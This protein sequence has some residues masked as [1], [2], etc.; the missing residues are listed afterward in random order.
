MVSYGDLT[1]WIHHEKLRSNPWN[2]MKSSLGHSGTD[3]VKLYTLL[4]LLPSKQNIETRIVSVAIGLAL[5]IAL[6]LNWNQWVTGSFAGRIPIILAWAPHYTVGQQIP[7]MVRV[8]FCYGLT[9]IFLVVKL[10]ICVKQQHVWCK[11]L[12]MVWHFEPTAVVFFWTIFGLTIKHQPRLQQATHD[13]P[14]FV[15]D[16]TWR[17][18]LNRD[19]ESV[20]VSMWH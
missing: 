14:F 17:W 13:L 5:C 7:L 20:D 2:P 15:G 1:I 11:N 16:G 6:F 19:A 3:G 18:L 9:T 4:F 10:D 12:P 8:S